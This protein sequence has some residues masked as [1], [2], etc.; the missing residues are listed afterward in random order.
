MTLRVV[1]AEDGAGAQMI[2]GVRMPSEITMR[3]V[4][5]LL[6][7]AK[8]SRNHSPAQV[9][10]LAHS[11][12]TVGFTNPILVADNGILAG[13]G[14]LLAA[15]K[16]NLS[17]VP[18]IDLSHLSEDERRALVIWDNR[19]AELG[20]TWDLEMLKA[21][22]DYL[23]DV[24]MDLEFSTGFSEEAL[25]D[26]L[27]GLEEPGA[28]G[29]GDPDDAPPAP[30][31][32]VS[33]QGDVWVMGPH[34][35]AVGDSTSGEVWD[36][37]MDGELADVVWTDPPYGVDLDRKNRLLDGVTGGKRSEPNAIKNDKLT[38]DALG[39]F[40]AEAYA[41]LFEVMK[42]GA[43]IYVAHSDKEGGVFRAEF[44]KAGFTFSQNV[45]WK[46]N[47]LVLGMARYQPIHEPILVGRKPGSKSRW[48]GGRKQTTV[49]DLG[50]G[51][52]FTKMEDGRWQIRLG[53]SFM[54][55]AGE[56]IV[57]EHPSSV[58]NV[59]KP[60]KSGLHQSQKPVELV[61]RQLRNS[62]RP[63]DL[64]AD[65][66]GGSGSTLV[67]A[68]RLG[69]IARLVEQDEAFADVI[70]TRWQMLTGRRAVHAVTG[71]PFPILGEQRAPAPVP[72][73]EPEAD[74]SDIF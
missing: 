43:S 36:A 32:P 23:R 14:R 60:A 59:A 47:Q 5:E 27:S 64:V 65:A 68:D 12:R 8:N 15:E 71:E 35:L 26:L 25:A 17:R 16:L 31:E 67:A 4:A 40:L 9:E 51:G 46:K 55:V 74:G 54:I 63:G 45:I 66:F 22:T 38:G 7:Y 19:S 52:P 50:E 1:G 56:A 42:P 11:M 34:R 61:E 28:E 6:P 33:V 62:A 37:L 3:L 21:E 13:H 10:A 41:R 72:A 2:D 73:A 20:S 30:D 49:V 18:C 44:E 58:L 57:E 24:G 70:V 29:G 39:A 69:M 48:Y 53:D